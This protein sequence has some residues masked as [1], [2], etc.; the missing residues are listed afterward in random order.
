MPDSREMT[1]MALS[2][3]SMVAFA[4]PGAEP[5]AGVLTVAELLVSLLWQDRPIPPEEQPVTVAAFNEAMEGLKDEIRNT[6]LD[7]KLQDDTNL[8]MALIKTFHANWAEATKVK[9]TSDKLNNYYAYDFVQDDTT[10]AFVE[11]MDCYFAATGGTLSLSGPIVNR[12]RIDAG[13]SSDALARRNQTF[14]LFVLVGT[15]RV[16]YLKAAVAWRWCNE[17]LAVRAWRQWLAADQQWKKNPDPAHPE[18]Q[19]IQPARSVINIPAWQDWIKEP[20]CPVPQLIKEV[21]DLLSYAEDQPATATDPASEGV[22]TTLAKK[23]PAR[24]SNLTARLSQITVTGAGN[25]YAVSDAGANYA[26]GPFPSKLQADKELEVAIGVQIASVWDYWTEEGRLDLIADGEVDE[27]GKTLQEW[28]AIRDSVK[29]QTS[30]PWQGTNT[31]DDLVATFYKNDLR[32]DRIL[33]ANPLIIPSTRKVTPG[34]QLTIPK[35]DGSQPA[36]T[37]TVKSGDTLDSIAPVLYPD[38][39]LV[40]WILQTNRDKLVA[41]QASTFQ[42]GAILKLP[43]LS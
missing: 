40:Q 28:K 39:A 15:L 17:V 7:A 12:V 9:T 41:G 37:Y 11:S 16:S 22:Y 33:A 4:I 8:I 43:D 23:W 35:L 2:T 42:T 3:A 18:L 29:F 27:F 19:P 24:M 36:A 21:N 38:S 5:L 31:V 10:R 34:M 30:L 14:R 13:S 1:E 20:G 32:A 25:S 6:L 26:I